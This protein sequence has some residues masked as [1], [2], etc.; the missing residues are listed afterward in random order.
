MTTTLTEAAK[1]EVRKCLIPECMSP[2]ESETESEPSNDEESEEEEGETRQKKK[3][4]VVRPLSWRSQRFNDYLASFDRKH[5]R[6][7]SSKS[8]M[9]TK[10]R[11]QGQVIVCDPPHGIPNWMKL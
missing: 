7:K 11:T 9:M 10:E 3:K 4:I 2:E 1:Q 8:T 6:R 5:N